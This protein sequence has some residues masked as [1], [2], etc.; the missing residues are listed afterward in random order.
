MI[1]TPHRQEREDNVARAARDN[2]R[3]HHKYKQ[4]K[5]V[6]RTQVK[7]EGDKI[8]KRSHC[9]GEDVAGM[10]EDRRGSIGKP[11]S[12]KKSGYNTQEGKRNDNVRVL[13]ETD[14]QMH[15]AAD[16]PSSQPGKKNITEAADAQGPY[17]ADKNCFDRLPVEAPY[18]GRCGDGAHEDMKRVEEVK[19]LPKVYGRFWDLLDLQQH[20]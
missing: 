19:E 1:V 10:G 14:M 17:D 3:Q 5:G 18:H 8:E 2:N 15:V 12:N 11:A 7:S 16:E 13:D 9:T 4:H 20:G 6:F